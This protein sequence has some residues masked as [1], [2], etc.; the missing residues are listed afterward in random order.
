MSEG[1]EKVL[2]EALK[3]TTEE[4]AHLAAEQ[5]ASVDGEPE[6]DA[7]RAWAA[8]IDRRIDIVREGGPQGEPWQA[9]HDRIADRLRS[10]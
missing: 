10:K 6:A 2:T 1:A 7:T 4:R 5:I 9:V 8:E 3:L